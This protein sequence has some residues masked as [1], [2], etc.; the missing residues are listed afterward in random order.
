M[1][2]L[3]VVI[4]SYVRNSWRN[5]ERHGEIEI[6]A[7]VDVLSE[8]YEKLKLQINELLT[9]IDAENQLISDIGETEKELQSKTK[10]LEN[11]NNEIMVAKGQVNRLKAFLENLGINPAD[12]VLKVGTPRLEKSTATYDV[13]ENIAVEA[14]VNPLP[15]DEST[16]TSSHEF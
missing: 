15:F 5:L 13:E 14:E 9:K 2:K 12:Y 10:T 3:K 6:S 8:G 16:D 11:L 1:Y 4:N 7:E